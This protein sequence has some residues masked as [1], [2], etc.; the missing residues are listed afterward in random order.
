LFLYILVYINTDFLGF[1]RPTFDSGIDQEELRADSANL[2]SDENII[3]DVGTEDPPNLSAADESP[4]LEEIQK[5]RTLHQTEEDLIFPEMLEDSTALDTTVM[6]Q[7]ET[8]DAL[9]I[10]EDNREVPNRELDT[11]LDLTPMEV[12]ITEPNLNA[13]ATDEDPTEESYVINNGLNTID[14][15]TNAKVRVYL[16]AHVRILKGFLFYRLSTGI[17]VCHLPWRRHISV[18]TLAYR[19]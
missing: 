3:I 19:T 9:L 10:I 14:E 1:R 7:S 11:E 6:D 13:I 4:Q 16:K 8:N 15:E 2:P 17:A 18:R 5:A 12:D